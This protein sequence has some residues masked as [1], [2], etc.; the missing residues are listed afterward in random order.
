MKTAFRT[1]IGRIRAVNEDCAAV[2]SDL[3]GIALAVLADGMGGHKA[4]DIASHTAI[5]VMNRELKHIHHEMS[6]KQWEESIVQAV[7]RANAEVYGKATLHPEFLGMGTTLVAAL[8]TDRRLMVAH[9]GDS[10]AYLIHKGQLTLLTEDHSLVNELL[11]SGQIS[12]EEADMHPR[13]NVLTR[14]LGT[15]QL[16]E[17]DIRHLDWDKGDILLLCSDGLSNSLEDEDILHILHTESTLNGK[18]DQLIER[19]LMAGGE[20]NVTVVLIFNDQPVMRKG[21]TAND[22]TRTGRAI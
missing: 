22:R 2:H 3:S 1:D 21:G 4:G 7:S 5:E 20:D 11:K 13:R 12:K 8:A 18:A 6:P 15:E 16:I 14:A 19:A 17:A 9:I 10:R